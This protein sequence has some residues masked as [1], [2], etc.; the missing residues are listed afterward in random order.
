MNNNPYKAS[1]VDLE[2]QTAKIESRSLLLL[3]T[4]LI[5]IAL[6]FF[7][8]YSVFSITD[9][10]ADYKGSIEKLDELS[11]RIEKQ[12]ITLKRETLLEYF[13]TNRESVA[14][15]LEVQ[16]RSFFGFLF[17]GLILTI[18]SILQLIVFRSMK[19]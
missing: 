2:N 14:E 4:T 9:L 17:A 11:N 10:S 18:V 6:A 13:E 7:C 12:E 5:L 15:E 19:K 16:N 8:F 3:I 1:E